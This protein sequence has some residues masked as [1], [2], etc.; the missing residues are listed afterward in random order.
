MHV[1]ILSTEDA[2][3]VTNARLSRALAAHDLS[4]GSTNPDVLAAY[5]HWMVV[6]ALLGDVSFDEAETAV[7]RAHDVFEASKKRS[8][9][10]TGR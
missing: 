2:P 9:P 4:E 10:I 6:S 5:I 8:A 1:I 7:G 3:E